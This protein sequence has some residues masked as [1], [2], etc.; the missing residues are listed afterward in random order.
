[1]HYFLSANRKEQ[2]SV[3]HKT[4]FINSVIFM[5]S[6][7]SSLTDHLAKCLCKVNCKGCKW[8]LEYMN[9][10]WFTN[11]ELFGQEHNI[12][13]FW[14]RFTQKISKYTNFL[15][16]TWTNNKFF[17]MSWKGV[18]PYEYMDGWQRFSETSLPTKKKFYNN[19]TLESITNTD[20]WKCGKSGKTLNYKT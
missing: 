5:A 13:K 12:E 8:S 15:I 20:Q 4:R 16:E 6:P 17:L 14:W 1:M 9:K 3:I 10:E 7:L 11:I 18:Y 19:Q 2:K